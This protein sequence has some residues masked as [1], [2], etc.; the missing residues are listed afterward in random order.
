MRLLGLIL[1]LFL[2]L[3]GCSTAP[4]RT[5]GT[6][7]FEDSRRVVIVGENINPYIA[8]YYQHK[9]DALVW[10]TPYEGHFVNKASNFL[11]NGF[12]SSTAMRSLIAELKSVNYTVGKWEII[13]PGIAEGYFLAT[14]KNMDD[15][16]LAKAR[17]SIVLPESKGNK[18]MEQ[19]V[20][21]VTDGNFFV[22]YGLYQQ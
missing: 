20:L 3:A 22:E 15:H 9:Y 4:P 2:L 7:G 18:E 10:F 16:S 5:T 13:V 12:G 17:G 8:T 11:Q 19:Q 21:R 1:S 14:L 6:L